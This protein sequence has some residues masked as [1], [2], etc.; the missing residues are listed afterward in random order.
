MKIIHY[1]S[2]L[3]I[4]ALTCEA[5]AEVHSV[6]DEDPRLRA[7]RVAARRAGAQ[8]RGGPA[9]RAAREAGP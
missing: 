3:F 8:E 1:Y 2:L 4:R 9:Q 6:E 5:E 7:E